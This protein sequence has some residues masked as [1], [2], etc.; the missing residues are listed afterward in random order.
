MYKRL[1]RHCGDL[2][3]NIDYYIMWNLRRTGQM[4]RGR[5]VKDWIWSKD[6]TVVGCVSILE[7]LNDTYVRWV[8]GVTGEVGVDP[9]DEP[10]RVDAV[11]TGQDPEGYGGR[12]SLGPV[13]REGA[14]QGVL[15]G[16]PD[17]L[18]RYLLL[19]TKNLLVSFQSNRNNKIKTL[20]ISNGQKKI[21]FQVVDYKRF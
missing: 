14:V 17:V 7:D 10:L 12:E 11:L 13:Q 3:F 21:I 5:L 9:E 2:V 6:K 20:N 16:A 8:A 19:R 4:K 15:T 1:D 18:E